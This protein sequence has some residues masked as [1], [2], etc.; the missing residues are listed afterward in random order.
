[1][2]DG[3]QR[4]VLI[5]LIALFSLSGVLAL[6]ASVLNLDWFFKARNARL[7]TGKMSRRTARLVYFIIG[8]LILAMVWKLINEIM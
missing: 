5:V 6:V 4:I 8:A 3:R 7:L 1:M 2:I